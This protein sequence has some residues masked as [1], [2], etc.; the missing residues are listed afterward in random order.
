MTLSAGCG[1][2]ERLSAFDDSNEER[3]NLKHSGSKSM[4]EIFTCMGYVTWDMS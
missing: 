4:I 1:L 2:A 3:Q